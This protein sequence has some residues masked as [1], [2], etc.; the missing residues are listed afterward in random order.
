[1][2]KL[3]SAEIPVIGE[4]LKLKEGEGNNIAPY[5]ELDAVGVGEKCAEWV[6]ESKDRWSLHLQQ[7]SFDDRALYS[8]VYRKNQTPEY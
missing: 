8:A 7:K 2:D 6:I 3:N 4:I 5:V 1:M